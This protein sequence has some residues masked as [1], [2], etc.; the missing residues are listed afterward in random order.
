VKAGAWRA[1]A[2]PPRGSVLDAADFHHIVHKQRVAGG[3]GLGRRR[4]EWLPSGAAARASAIKDA[5]PVVA[6]VSWRLYQAM[7]ESMTRS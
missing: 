1:Y 5:D 3:R 6:L 4:R 7:W 2:G